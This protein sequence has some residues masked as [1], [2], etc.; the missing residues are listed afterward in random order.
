MAQDVRSQKADALL[1]S[2]QQQQGGQLKIFLGAAPGVGKTCAMLNAAKELQQQGTAVCIGLV[3]THGRAE[4]EALLQGCAL[5]PR[6][7]IH[8]TRLIGSDVRYFCFYGRLE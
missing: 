3:E 4:T 7:T 8:Q 2:L 6:K 1:K 5:L